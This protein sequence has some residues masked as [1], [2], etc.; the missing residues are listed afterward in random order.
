M[1]CKTTNK[2]MNFIVCMLLIILTFLV[3]CTTNQNTED[4][5][6]LLKHKYSFY[7]N[8][9]IEIIVPF[10]AGGGTDIFARFMS[11]ILS[12]KI[13]GNPTV[14]VVNIPGDNSIIGTNEFVYMSE[15]NGKRLFASSG[16]VHIPYLLGVRAVKYDL[17]DLEPI[18]GLPTG[19][20][21][22]ISP[23]TGVKNPSD[24]KKLDEQL[25]Y[26]GISATG[27]DLV[28]LLAFE[29]L[30]LDV[31]TIFDF[32][33]RKEAS[34][35]F[36]NGESTIDFQTTSSYIENILPLYKRN[37]AIPLFSFG[38]INDQG[39]LV[40]DPI[41]SDLPTL[42][43]V[44]IDIYGKSPSGEAWEAYKAFVNSAYTIQKVIWTHGDAPDAAKQA[45]NLAIAKAES[46]YSFNKIGNN[47]HERYD[48][49]TGSELKAMIDNAFNTPPEILNW[50]R[51]LLKNKYGIDN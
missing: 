9:E 47:F 1:I 13:P 43:E 19:G 48:P 11:T 21:V 41:F 38:Q 7:K 50:V 24:L 30:E 14:K 5:E 27:L 10:E 18:I 15:P 20:V 35:A 34:I 4:K 26:R 44:Y 29:V 12:K 32:E 16:S 25:V 37:E 45:L 49:Y 6:I 31:Q 17:R 28:M 3:G 22:Y 40:R 36:K 42:K 33:G 2:K 46:D 8:E 23:N 39:K 51:E